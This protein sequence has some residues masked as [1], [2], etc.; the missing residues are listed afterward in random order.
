MTDSVSGKR[1]EPSFSPDMENQNTNDT[2]SHASAFSKNSRTTGRSHGLRKS[3]S[4]PGVIQPIPSLQPILEEQPE[5]SDSDESLFEI[6]AVLSKLDTKAIIDIPTPTEV[7]EKNQETSYFSKRRRS[8]VRD[9][10]KKK[11]SQSAAAALFMRN[12]VLKF[13]K[14]S[15]LTRCFF[16]WIPFALILFVPL[17]IGAWGSPS[18]E[19]GHTRLMWLFIWFEVIWAALWISRIFAACVPT[20]FAFVATVVAPGVKKYKSV[21]Y[22]MQMPLAMVVWTLIAVSTFYPIMTRG[23]NYPEGN[24]TGIR[25]WHITVQNI[26]VASLISCIVYLVERLVIHLISVSF[27]KTRFSVRILRNKKSIRTLTELLYCSCLAFPPFCPEFSEEDMKLQTGKFYMSSMEKNSTEIG[28]KIEKSKVPGWINGHNAQKFFGTVNYMVD[29]TTKTLG[30][31]ARGQIVDG[32]DLRAWVKSTI[33]DAIDSPVLSEVLARRIWLS[34]V[35]EDA[36]VLTLN[37]IIAILGPDRVKDSRDIYNVLDLDGNGELTMEEMM[38]AVLS[39]SEERKFIYNSL[40][41]VD[42]AIDKLNKVLLFIVLI[43]VVVIFVGML[44]PSASAVLATVGTSL[45]AFSF[46]F[47]SSAQEIIS[48]FIFLFIKHPL[49]VGDRVQILGEGYIVAEL[50]LLFT[51]FTRIADNAQVQA[52][53]S[54]LNTLWIDNWTRSGPQVFGASLTLGLPDTTLEQVEQ[55]A[56]GLTAYCAE[57]PKDYVPDPWIGCSAIPDLDR[58]SIGI[59]VTFNDNF[60]D[61]GKFV[62]RRD[63]LVKAIGRLINDLKLV[64]PR[65]EDSST[66]PGLPFN[67]SGLNVGSLDYKHQSHSEDLSENMNSSKETGFRRGA[68]GFGP[69]VDI[70]DSLKFEEGNNAPLIRSS[71][72]PSITSGSLKNITFGRR[73]N[74]G[75]YGT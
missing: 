73:R 20:M 39:I 34:L 46:A 71:K 12:L 15:L 42:S 28:G 1:T 52:P 38:S 7:D 56:E 44:A 60:S 63:R 13:I 10:L 19:I 14:F 66:D 64:V 75:D 25:T 43:I 45:L 57:N 37:D 26:L 36:E 2:A 59:A 50:S 9:T 61:G 51:V 74:Y 16:Y 3:T 11:K 5:L 31:V 29:V 22:A 48:S 6:K 21:L 23:T 67:L 70:G 55:F 69:P 8:I 4:T 35:L 68:L 72:A 24:R 17:A 53:N 41:N 54:V 47:S 18:A 33:A 30:K 32:Y 65:R 62:S 40:R 27:H 49:D 58:V